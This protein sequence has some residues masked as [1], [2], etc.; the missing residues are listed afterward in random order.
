MWEC[1]RAEP[2]CWSSTRSSG[3]CSWWCWRRGSW[4]PA[5]TPRTSRWTCWRRSCCCTGGSTEWPAE[6]RRKCQQPWTRSRDRARQ[7]RGSSRSLISWRRSWSSRVRWAPWWW[8]WRTLMTRAVWPDI[9]PSW[10][11]LSGDSR[12]LFSG[13]WEEIQPGWPWAKEILLEINGTEKKL[14][15]GH[16]GWV[17]C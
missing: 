12:T 15:R 10:E 3:W 7:Q 1:S 6:S 8:C 5:G 11:C 17:K 13:R 4:T 14:L 2:L 16:C 9:A